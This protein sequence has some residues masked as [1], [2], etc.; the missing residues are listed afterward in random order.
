MQSRSRRFPAFDVAVVGTGVLGTA[1]SH[2][3]QGLGL[4]VLSIGPEHGSPSF[5]A[6]RHFR[7]NTWLG[8]LQHGPYEGF[9]RRQTRARFPRADLLDLAASELRARLEVT[10]A[11]S[12]ATRIVL[13]ASGELKVSTRGDGRF[14][15][16]AALLAPGWGRG[17]GPRGVLDFST[18][19]TRLAEG[20]L[21]A[22]RLLVVGGGPSALS[23]LEACA[24]RGP[25]RA[26]RL[27]A[28]QH[29]TWMTGTLHTPRLPRLSAMFTARYG[30]L[31]EVLADAP[32]LAR[33]AAKVVTT[34]RRAAGWEAVDDQGARHRVDEVVWCGGFEAPLALLGPDT[35]VLRE[36]GV[37]LGLQ[38]VGAP[39]FQVGAALDQLGLASWDT[40]PFAE[41]YEKGCRVLRRLSR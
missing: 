32:W 22:R 36:D 5:V 20:R 24:G 3:A 30:R 2:H 37:A 16:R 1:L 9:L 10:R 6:G 15:A 14:R 18:A 23:F 26:M 19:L 13:T 7:L 25:L 12:L 17:K 35:S 33:R 11:P 34:R 40:G 31:L 38:R 29:V 41:W 8:D 39:L 27:R 21:E 4:S 28:D